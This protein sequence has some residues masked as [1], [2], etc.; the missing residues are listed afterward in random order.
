MSQVSMLFTLDDS[1]FTETADTMAIVSLLHNASCSE[2]HLVV[3]GNDQST[4]YKNWIA[5]LETRLKQKISELLDVFF[6][7]ASSGRTAKTIKVRHFEGEELAKA[8]GLSE[9]DITRAAQLA[10]RA[11]HVYVENSRNDKRFLL[12]ACTEAQRARFNRLIAKNAIQIVNGGGITELKKQIEQDS[13]DGRLLADFAW[14]MFDSDALTSGMPSGQSMRLKG[15]CD[16]LGIKTAQLQ[17]R[18]IENYATKD[19][20]RKWAF[21]GPKSAQTYK[22]RTQNFLEYIALPKPLARHYNMKNGISGDRVR[23][24]YPANDKIY[25]NLKNTS[26]KNL[27]S[28]FGQH[29]SDVFDWGL[30]EVALKSEGSWTELQLII[31]EL[32]SLL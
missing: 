22:Q 31:T 27:E 19:S 23:A 13:R 24:D 20:L 21:T 8:P 30:D 12:A 14:V 10:T 29:V 32:E 4:R 1:L 28:G 7:S 9:I 17:F 11:F 18:S 6:R 15:T 5:N 3:I 2:R 16:L 26:I 25:V